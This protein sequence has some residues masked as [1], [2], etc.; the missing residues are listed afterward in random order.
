M[1]SSNSRY[2]LCKFKKF[3]LHKSIDNTIGLR[4]CETGFESHP[5]LPVLSVSGMEAIGD[6]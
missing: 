4:G 6:F 2:R 5:V 1:F 3:T